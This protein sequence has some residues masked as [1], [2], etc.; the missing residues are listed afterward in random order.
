MIVRLSA[1]FSLMD[2]RA[3]SSYGRPVLV[4]QKTGEAYGP[5]DIIKTVKGFEPAARVVERL[6]A[7]KKFTDEQIEFIKRF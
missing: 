3:E 7:K 1:K 6:T 4:N 5:G 2:Q